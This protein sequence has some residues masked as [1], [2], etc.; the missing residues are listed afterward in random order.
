MKAEE[1]FKEVLKSPELQSIF[2]IS[3]KELEN[4]NL[5]EKSD[6][7]VVEIIKEIINGQESHKSKD[8]I[9]QIIQKQ[10]MQL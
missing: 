2:Q 5:H 6:F 7:P 3:T 10:I 4:V 9:F 1:I 8:Q